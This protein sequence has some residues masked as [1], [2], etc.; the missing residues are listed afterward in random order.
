MEWRTIESAPYEEDILMYGSYIYPDDKYPTV[1]IECGIKRRDIDWP[2][3][4]LEGL[5]A[6][7]FYTHW[8]PLP[9]PPTEESA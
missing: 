8:M 1:Y 3:E 6:P 4:D 9:E 5:K 2:F 7:G